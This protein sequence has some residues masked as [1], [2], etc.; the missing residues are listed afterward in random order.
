MIPPL[1]RP[2]SVGALITHG[3]PHTRKGGG[4]ARNSNFR[5]ALGAGLQQGLGILQ[6]FRGSTRRSVVDSGK[7]TTEDNGFCT[8]CRTGVALGTEP[9]LRRAERSA[10]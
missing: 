9:R 10:G 8:N 5:C 7:T 2:A 1:V 6:K 4:A 3:S